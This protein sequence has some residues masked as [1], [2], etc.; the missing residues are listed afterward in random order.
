MDVSDEFWADGEVTGAGEKGCG[1]GLE[2]GAAIVDLSDGIVEQRKNRCTIGTICSADG[3]SAADRFLSLMR[4]ASLR[5]SGQS[6]SE[7]RKNEQRKN[8]CTIC[9]ADWFSAANEMRFSSRKCTIW[10]WFSAA[11]EMRFSPR[12]CTIWVR[13]KEERTEEEQMHDRHDL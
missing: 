2:A 5:G 10:V 6:G 13:T 1:G 3:F 9:S 11:D 8:R 12:K 4:C 7:Q